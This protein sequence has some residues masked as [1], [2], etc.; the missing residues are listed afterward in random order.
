MHLMQY[1][2]VPNTRENK[3]F[4]T[5]L[6]DWYQTSCYHGIIQNAHVLCNNGMGLIDQS[7]YFFKVISYYLFHSLHIGS[8][9]RF[10]LESTVKFYK[11]FS[12]FYPPYIVMGDNKLEIDK[13]MTLCCVGRNH[14]DAHLMV[15]LTKLDSQSNQMANL[16]NFI[17]QNGKMKCQKFQTYFFF[18][19]EF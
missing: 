10:A 12:S 5:C 4:N 17:R 18:F 15:T 8:M 19:D 14:F 7:D 16:S 2:L 6:Q 13:L 9:L 3:P 1:N 11:Q